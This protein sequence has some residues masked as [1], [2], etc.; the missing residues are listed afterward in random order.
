MQWLTLV[1]RDRDEL[2][3]PVIDTRADNGGRIAVP[4]R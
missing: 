2:R 3:H 1:Q 4:A